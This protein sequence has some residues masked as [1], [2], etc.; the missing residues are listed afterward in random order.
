MSTTDLAAAVRT[1][2]LKLGL[3]QADLKAKG[4]PAVTTV[5]K[6]ENARLESVAPGT[7]A[8][9]DRALGWEHGTAAG[10]L[11]GDVA[12]PVQGASYVADQGDEPLPPGTRTITE[13]DLLEEFR[14]VRVAL[15]QINEKLDRRDSP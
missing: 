3:D 2:R 12:P 10:I 8:G 1:R 5:N 6:I 4:G 13:Q 14:R 9:L 7:L 15:E 11:S